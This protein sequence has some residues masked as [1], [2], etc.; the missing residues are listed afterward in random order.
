[1]EIDLVEHAGLVREFQGRVNQVI[2]EDID[3]LPPAGRLYP[4]FYIKV[5]NFQL[6]HVK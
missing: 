2:Q 3:N 5:Q 1:M 6:R 4:K